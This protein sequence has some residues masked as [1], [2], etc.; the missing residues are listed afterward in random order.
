MLMLAV[1]HALE[2]GVLSRGFHISFASLCTTGI[3]CTSKL[4]AHKQCIS[5]LSPG[6]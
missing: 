4:G 2:T 1:T 3:K 6:Q 5:V